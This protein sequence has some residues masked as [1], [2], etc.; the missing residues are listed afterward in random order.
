MYSI[1]RGRGSIFVDIARGSGTIYLADN[2]ILHFDQKMSKRSVIASARRV[3][4][5]KS[6]GT[7]TV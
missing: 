4:I 1:I 6:S 7:L 3:E 5:V 2:T